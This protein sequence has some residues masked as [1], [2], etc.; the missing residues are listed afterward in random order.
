[1]LGDA[2]VK[3][4]K[5]VEGEIY[6]QA[7][8]DHQAL[9]QLIDRASTEAG[10]QDLDLLKNLGAAYERVGLIPEAK[11]W[12]KLALV[13]D[14]ADAG[15]QVALYH[16]GVASARTGQYQFG[17]SAHARSGKRDGPGGPSG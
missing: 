10:R 2:L 15:V 4:G 6:L 1:M 14:P 11:A 9:Y 3:S 12:Y 5:H 16:L 8:R 7:A 17:Q 13:R